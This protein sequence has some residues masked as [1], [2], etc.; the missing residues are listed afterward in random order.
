MVAKSLEDSW[1]ALGSLDGA[2]F[3]HID[4]QPRTVLRAISTPALRVSFVLHGFCI[5]NPRLLLI[6][7][8]S[9]R[10]FSAKKK[11]VL[12]RY[13]LALPPSQEQQIFQN[14]ASGLLLIFNQQLEIVQHSS[15][16]V[17]FHLT[18]VSICHLHS[19]R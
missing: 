16:K 2:F 13:F 5:E 17:L 7:H 12:L 19:Q 15:W 18:S 8:T 10:G 4:K 14:H 6:P 11:N 9:T 3:L 1:T